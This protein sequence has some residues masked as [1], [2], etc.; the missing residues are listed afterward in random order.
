MAH[1]S[2]R[3]AVTSPPECSRREIGHSESFAISTAIGFLSTPVQTALRDQPVG[4]RFALEWVGGNLLAVGERRRPGA[5]G[6][7]GL[8]GPEPIAMSATFRS[9]NSAEVLSFHF[10]GSRSWPGPG[11]YATG[12]SAYRTTPSARSRGV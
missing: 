5:V 6:C 8:R 12:S 1:S 11:S 2:S 4:E 7:S 9:S 10:A 3:L